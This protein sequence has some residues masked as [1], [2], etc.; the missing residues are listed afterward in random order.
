MTGDSRILSS[1]TL[2]LLVFRGASALS[3][4]NRI[5]ALAGVRR[6]LY[7]L[8]RA[9]S[10]RLFVWSDSPSAVLFSVTISFYPLSNESFV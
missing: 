5:H 6:V 10:F 3:F 1:G 9:L 8:E 4:F 7:S 2:V